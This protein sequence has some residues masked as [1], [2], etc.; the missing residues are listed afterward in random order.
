MSGFEL[1]E[2]F[3]LDR[4]LLCFCCL[5]SSASSPGW[6]PGC[7]SA[8]HGSSSI[9]SSNRARRHSA[10]SDS[11]DTG[12]GTSCSDSVEGK[13][14]LKNHGVHLFT[15]TKLLVLLISQLLVPMLSLNQSDTESGIFAVFTLHIM[16]L[17]YEEKKS[18]AENWEWMRHKRYRKIIQRFR[19]V[20]RPNHAKVCIWKSLRSQI[21]FIVKCSITCVNR[22]GKHTPAPTSETSAVII[23][24]VHNNLKLA[25]LKEWMLDGICEDQ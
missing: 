6:V 3:C 11:A 5:G 18:L 9:S 20:L 15:W 2:C 13:G 12:I 21:Y 7:E 22:G 17:N 23:C 1:C 19:D 16:K 25:G 24:N 4:V 10:A 14:H 8:W